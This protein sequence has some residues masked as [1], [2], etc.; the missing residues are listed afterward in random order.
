MSTAPTLAPEAEAELVALNDAMRRLAAY[1][2]EHPRETAVRFRHQQATWDILIRGR[3]PITGERLQTK[4]REVVVVAPNQ[5]GKSEIGGQIMS[6][7]ANRV[8]G[9]WLWTGAETLSVS[10]STVEEKLGSYLARREVSRWVN[11]GNDNAEGVIHLAGG[12]KI[13]C[14]SYDQKRE[15]WQG[16]PIRAAWIDEQPPDDIVQELRMRCVRY[17]SP[18]LYTFTPLGGVA[19][20]LYDDF[21]V[22]FQ[23]WM[24]RHGKPTGQ[25]CEVC[26]WQERG[27]HAVEVSPGR[28][29]VTARIRDNTF[30]DAE[31]VDLK[32]RAVIK[33]GRHLE[34]RVRFHG[35]WLDIGEDRIIPVDLLQ[36]YSEP[37]P[38]GYAGRAYWLDAAQSVASDACRSAIA[39][40]G[41]RHRGEI[42]LIDIE[43]GRWEPHERDAR[44]AEFIKRHGDAPAYVQ[45]TS[46][47]EAVAHSVNQALS[48]AGLSTRFMPWP[49]RGS[50]QVV[51]GKLERAHMFAPLVASGVFRCRPEH[52][53]LKRQMGLA[54][55][56]VLKKGGGPG[57]QI[58]DLDAAMGAAL[59]LFEQRGHDDW[60]RLV[61][62]GSVSHEA[63]TKQ[64]FGE[65][66]H[67]W[68]DEVGESHEWAFD[69]DPWGAD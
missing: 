31:D 34:A 50:G 36:Q 43:G 40:G 59:R 13:R 3:H 49:A 15:R 54:S 27:P 55:Q 46:F 60:K 12:A 53:E 64:G 25:E 41:R 18:I 28:W 24:D 4:P 67:D 63:A 47:D 11:R 21:Y 19:S 51:Q 30:L 7:I 8:R 32:E 22:P 45:R 65:D 2:A 56:E 20:V 68:K 5:C 48:R 9:G 14:K 61:R 33:A 66:S 16:V 62:D 52:V 23:E 37:P 26:G 69:G 35:E 58:D 10:T 6:E 1:D 17:G 57:I 38:D 42:D 39:L 44:V 29:V